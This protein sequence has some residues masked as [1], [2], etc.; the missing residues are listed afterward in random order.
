MAQI[1]TSVSQLIGG[2]PLLEL[3]RT[4]EGG[5]LLV[6]P[7]CFNP[8]GS[9]KDRAALGMLTAARQQGLLQAVRPCG[10]LGAAVHHRHA[11]IHE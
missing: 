11:R 6:K 4:P 5:R 7:E 10:S 1:F 8:T 2:T 3:C 9:A